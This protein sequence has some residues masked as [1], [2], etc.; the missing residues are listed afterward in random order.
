MRT[1]AIAHR[2][3]AANAQTPKYSTA[4]IKHQTNVLKSFISKRIKINIL[5]KNKSHSSNG[6]EQMGLV[7]IWLIS[8]TFCKW[9]Q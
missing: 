4:P 5:Y 9:F 6:C 2:A 7:L 8:N 3:K 1:K